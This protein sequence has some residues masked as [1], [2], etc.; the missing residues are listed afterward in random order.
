V[1]DIDAAIGY[2][3]AH[4]D[5]VERARLSYLRTGATPAQQV[6]DRIGA[7]QT[8]SGGWPA[9]GDGTVASVDATCF[10]LA[11][12][13]DLGAL[14]TPVAAS[15]L[16]WLAGVQRPDGTW[17]ED[18]SLAAEAPP[19]AMPGDPEAQLYLTAVAGFW[20]ALADAGKRPR[21]APP[22]GSGP[23]AAMVRTAAQFVVGRLLPDGTWPSFLATGWYAAGLLHDQG[24]YYE[25]ARVQ[26]VLGDRLPGMS[27]ADVASMA[28]TL[29]RI[30][31]GDDYWLLDAARKRLGETQR[32]DGGWDSDEGPIF[33]VHATLTAIRACR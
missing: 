28:A 4:G 19:W 6:L 13:D 24:N 1:V 27:P 20:L 30:G 8:R 3:V 16:G 29:R 33:D 7:M 15:A 21:F 25:A 22:D 2:V 12:I 26:Y 14:H 31:T 32:S 9:S 23:Y 5:P 10:R 11:E 18:Q 17:E